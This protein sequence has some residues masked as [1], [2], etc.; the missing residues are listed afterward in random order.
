MVVYLPSPGLMPSTAKRERGRD[1]REK[2][3]KERKIERDYLYLK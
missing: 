1:E 3:E 2:R